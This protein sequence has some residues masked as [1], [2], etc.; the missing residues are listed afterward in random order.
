MINYRVGKSVNK[1]F[2]YGWI[3][4]LVGALGYFFSAPGQTYFLS[5]FI[6]SYIEEFKF[7]R[8]TIST[9][10]SVATFFSGFLLV[11]MGRAVDKSGQRKMY[12]IV[13][14]MLALACI[15]S[16]LVTNITL[17]FLSFFLLRYFGQGS[18]PL[19]SSSLVPQWFDK[20]KALAIG[21]YSLGGI[22][23]STFTPSI[24]VF[25]IDEFGW[26]LTWR[27]WSLLLIVIFIP[28]MYI[29]VINK[30]EDI[31]LK[32]DNQKIKSKEDTE[33]ELLIL[34]KESWKLVEALR[35]KEF[36]MVS[37]IAMIIPLITTGLA[38]HFFSIMS[39]KGIGEKS[40]SFAIGLMG[41]PGFF[42]PIAGLFIDR[43]KPKILI[44]LML[45]TIALNLLFMLS[46]NSILTASIFMLIYGLTTNVQNITINVT[47][48]TY[49]GRKYLGS[50]RGAAQVF[51]VVG[52]A[53]GPIPFG[54]SYDLT[55]SYNSAFTAMI[56]LVIVGAMLSL[57]IVNPKKVEKE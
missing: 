1:L 49:F 22:I 33:K 24:N 53:F 7:S 19:I 12:I 57:L 35:T 41:L 27:I 52:S 20:R 18:L 8:T 21:L 55:G 10:Y 29:F 50:I 15:L 17:I 47:Y 44:F 51:M 23:A 37:I 54:L 32:P 31:E 48:V 6:D 43:I 5:T 3:I 40:A 36:W 34:E 30:P 2:Y 42:M 11:F 39:S 4:I 28:I 13:G 25:L 45:T 26:R 14:S 46:V 38:F 9:L 56:F 16:S